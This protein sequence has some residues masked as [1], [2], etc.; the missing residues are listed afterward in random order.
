MVIC[1]DGDFLVG[2]LCCCCVDG[3]LS[4][5]NGVI[6]FLGVIS[7]VLVGGGWC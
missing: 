3:L 7:F 4:W 6:V 2:L 1:V 5:E